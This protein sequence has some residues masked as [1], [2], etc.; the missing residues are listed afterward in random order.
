MLGLRRKPRIADNVEHGV[1][2]EERRR[3]RL[4]DHRRT[5]CSARRISPIWR[6]ARVGLGGKSREARFGWPDE[7][8]HKPQRK[9]GAQRIPDPDVLT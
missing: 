4:H 1:A 2:Q 6:M 9:Q 8:P 3:Q 7:T 5:V